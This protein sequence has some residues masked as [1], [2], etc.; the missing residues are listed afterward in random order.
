MET[1]KRT[2]YF[3]NDLN[4]EAYHFEG[5]M[6]KFPNHFHEYYVIGF[7]ER[8]QRHLICK[9]REYIVEKKDVL[10]FNPLDTHTCEQ[11]DGK[12]LDWRCL[13]IN[14]DVMHRVAAEITGNDHAPIFTTSVAAQSDAL[15]SLKY[16]HTSIMEGNKDFDKEETFYLLMEQLIADYTQPVAESVPQTGKEILAVCD[17][18]EKNYTE[19]ITLSDLSEVSG[20]NKYTLIRNFT[21]Q[22]GITPYQYLSTIRINNAKK[23]LESGILPIDAAHQSGFTD[24]SHFTRFFKNFIGLTPGRY[25]SLFYA[26]DKKATS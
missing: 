9:N 16:L 11:I 24:Q 10:L 12:T 6:Q 2:V 7:I 18:L 1:E 19:T 26:T 13:N 21:V 14:T 17:Y 20:F 8:G 25:Q 3:D 5:I 22:K 4:I 15:P 23:L